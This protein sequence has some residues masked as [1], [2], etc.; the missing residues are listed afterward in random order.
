MKKLLII[1]C[2]YSIKVIACGDGP[3]EL[4]VKMFSDDKTVQ[5]DYQFIDDSLYSILINKKFTKYELAPLC[6]CVSEGYILKSSHDSSSFW[7]NYCGSPDTL[8]NLIGSDDFSPCPAYVNI[9]KDTKLYK[10]IIRLKKYLEL[11]RKKEE[12]CER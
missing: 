5:S 4:N 11:L 1:L 8:I 7:L 2:L 6:G 3:T 12:K 9:K 10:S